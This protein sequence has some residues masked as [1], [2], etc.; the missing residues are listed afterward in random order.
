[1]SPVTQEL[2]RQQRT[3]LCSERSQGLH[4]KHEN[5]LFG[6][7]HALALPWVS[8]T[9]AQAKAGVNS[10][11]SEITQSSNRKILGQ[12]FQ[13]QHQHHLQKKER[14][15]LEISKFLSCPFKCSSKAKKA[16]RESQQLHTC[17]LKMLF[18]LNSREFFYIYPIWSPTCEQ[19]LSATALDMPSCAFPKVKRNAG[20]SVEHY[21][22]Q[23]FPTLHSCYNRRG[24]LR[25][26]LFLIK[27]LHLDLQN[28]EPPNYWQQKKKE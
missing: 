16:N 22:T 28:K 8:V 3:G 24:A 25:T 17:I 23:S 12:A 20:T 6:N 27:K 18:A 2:P 19:P 9:L 13:N 5:A 4:N 10:N 7:L 11:A 1:M 14:A 21:R 15:G 26:L